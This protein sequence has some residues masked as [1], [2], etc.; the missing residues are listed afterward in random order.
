VFVGLYGSD[1]C[2]VKGCVG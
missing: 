1:Y 2:E